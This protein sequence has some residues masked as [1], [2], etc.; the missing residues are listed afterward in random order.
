MEYLVL[1]KQKRYG[2]EDVDEFNT[3]EEA[4]KFA[5]EE[6]NHL[7]DNDK[8]NNEYFIILKSANPDKEAENHY[9]GDV[10]KDYKKKILKHSHQ[11]PEENGPKLM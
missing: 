4:E 6:Y 1:R 3:F 8:K 7:C 11:V 5:D 9:D 2:D 10:V